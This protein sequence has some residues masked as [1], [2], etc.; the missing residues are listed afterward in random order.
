[1]SAGSTCGPASSS[2]SATASA[3]AT[4][5]WSC[6][7]ATSGSASAPPGCGSTS[8][9]S[10]CRGKPTQ[11]EEDRVRFARGDRLR[12]PRPGHRP[13]G[14]GGQTRH[15]LTRSA[16]VAN[17]LGL[18]YTHPCLTLLA[19]FEQRFTT[20]GEI[21]D[22]T[23]MLFRIALREPRASCETGSF[24]SDSREGALAL[25]RPVLA[26]ILGLLLAGSVPGNGRPGPGRRPAAHR[27]RRQ[28]RRDHEPGADR[29]GQPRARHQ[30]CCPTTPRPGSG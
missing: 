7:A 10:T 17:Q 28:R 23:T 21:D 19:G 12:S 22:E 26:A 2:I 1:M 24:L 27:G 15:D 30:R 4:T 5:S 3:S 25:R 16:T 13:A 29:P 8:T 20:T 9:T 18:I 6:A 11:T 14:P